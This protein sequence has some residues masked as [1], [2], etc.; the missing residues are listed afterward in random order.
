MTNKQGLPL[1]LPPVQMYNS[2]E[3]MREALLK[4]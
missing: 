4:K 3:D 1:K 2:S